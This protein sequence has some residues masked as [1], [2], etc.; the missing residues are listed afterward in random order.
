MLQDN[1]C[2]LNCLYFYIRTYTDVFYMH[3]ILCFNVYVYISVPIYVFILIMN[4]GFNRFILCIKLDV[5]FFMLCQK[6]RNK[7]VIYIIEWWCRRF[8]TLRRCS[9][10]TCPFQCQKMAY[11][12]T[13]QLNRA[14]LELS[15]EPCFEDH[16]CGLYDHASYQN[17]KE[18]ICE[19]CH[20]S[21]RPTNL[22]HTLVWVLYMVTNTV[23]KPYILG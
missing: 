8:T 7:Q 20:F 15:P 3:C 21:I 18:C 17:K 11:P 1:K 9:N 23:A 4:P 19:T 16:T 12:L 6:W 10:N 2:V 22:A 14:I 13:F 5:L